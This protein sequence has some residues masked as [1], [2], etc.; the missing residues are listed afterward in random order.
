VRPKG[1]LPS[2]KFKRSH[3]KALEASKR[4]L[5]DLDDDDLSDVRQVR[6]EE[7]YDDYEEDAD[8]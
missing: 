8:D 5:A 3:Q 2:L 1:F 4:F 6:V 7:I